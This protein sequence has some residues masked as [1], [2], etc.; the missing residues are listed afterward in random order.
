[1]TVDLVTPDTQVPVGQ[2]RGADGGRAAGAALPPGGRGR[3]CRPWCSCTA[4]ASSSATSTPT[5][6][7]AGGCAP[8]AEVVGA[9]DRLPA[10][11]RGAV[12]RRGR[13]RPRRGRLGRRPPR[14]ARRR[15][16]ARGRLATPPAATC[17][18]SRAQVLRD[19]V[20]AQVLIYPATHMA[21]DYPSRVD[22]GEGYF[23]DMATMTWFAAHYLGESGRPR[24][25][26][27]PLA[28]A[29]RPRGRRARAGRHRRVR[30][31]ARRGRGLRRPASRRPGVP[32][33]RVRYDGLVHGFID[34]GL[35][36][37][38]A[39]AAL[40]DVVQRV[41]RLLRA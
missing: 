40:E 24:R 26:P 1:M 12:P 31:A 16:P 4:A 28:A 30:P 13:G 21:G 29:G 25:R 33:E 34:M 15:R 2:R 37:P 11:A 23:L 6:R 20:D 14:R 8:D 17:R 22:N 35:M 18:P 7:P 19:R 27:A 3:R 5:T 32:V 10:G 9:G 39:A 38:A 36:S 41:G